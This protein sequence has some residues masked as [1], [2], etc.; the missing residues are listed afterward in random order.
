[1]EKRG[2]VMSELKDLITKL[3]MEREHELEK[4]KTQAQRDYAK[5]VDV[6]AYGRNRAGVAGLN[7][8]FKYAGA[9]PTFS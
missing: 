6:S 7:G 5:D 9:R 4:H 8:L 1:M 3:K 2:I